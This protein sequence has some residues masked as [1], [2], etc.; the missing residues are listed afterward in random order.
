MVTVAIEGAPKVTPDGLL[1]L[2]L[3]V[4]L[5]STY[6]SSLISTMK[7]LEVSPGAKLRVPSAV[8]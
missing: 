3:K 7:L 6:E 8:M 1:R 4:S 2:T 5:P